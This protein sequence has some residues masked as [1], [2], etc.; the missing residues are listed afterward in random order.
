MNL[1]ANV[2]L[3]TI[4]VKAK[5]VLLAEGKVAAHLYVVRQ[6][7]VRIWLHH[8]G[9]EL[10][11]QF[12]VEG[13]AVA[14]LESFMTG[15]PSEF[16]LETVEQCTLEVLTKAEFDRLLAEHAGFREWFQQLT[17]RRLI[18]YVHHLL[19]YIRDTPQERYQ[20]LV[21][22][23]P[24]LL[25]RVPQHYIASYLGITGVSLSRIRNRK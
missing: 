15:E 23:R 20:R 9:K 21:K 13:E 5:T 16:T 17:T 6:G 8:R 22:N 1:F 7:C 14:S 3:P 10:T 18:G 11:A 24:Q 12:F 4:D 2:S 19:A 25:Q